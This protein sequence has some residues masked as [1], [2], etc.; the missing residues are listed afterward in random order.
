MLLPESPNLRASAAPL[1]RTELRL[2]IGLGRFLNPLYARVAK[3]APMS[4]A[5]DL[6]S[7]TTDSS[8]ASNP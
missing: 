2:H 6:I 1:V 7:T 8:I 3:K 5:G 4:G